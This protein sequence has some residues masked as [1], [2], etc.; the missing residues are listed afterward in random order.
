MLTKVVEEFRFRDESSL[1][2]RDRACH[3]VVNA[4]HVLVWKSRSATHTSEKQ[5]G[6]LPTPCSQRSY[7]YVTR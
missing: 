2:H 1:A 3:S 7:E 6:G 4:K 5:S